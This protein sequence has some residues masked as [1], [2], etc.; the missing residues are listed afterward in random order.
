[1]SE[2]RSGPFVTTV[3]VSVTLELEFHAR[4][5]AAPSMT[6]ADERGSFVD[7]FPACVRVVARH[8]LGNDNRTLAKILFID[9]ASVIADERH[10]T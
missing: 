10:N 3:T 5:V 2:A 6:I 7:L 9:H 4:C 1:M 8:P